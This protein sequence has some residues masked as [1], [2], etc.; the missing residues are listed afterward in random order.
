M[1]SLS[2]RFKLSPTVAAMTL[3]AFANGSPDILSVLAST[4]KINSAL[5]SLG[6]LF[7]A[8]LCSTTLVTSNVILNSPEKKVVLPKS[9]VLKDLIFYLISILIIIFFGLIQTAGYPLVITY[10]SCYILY[11]IVSIILEKKAA[12][13][14]LEQPTED[15]QINN[16]DI[17]TQE[18]GSVDEDQTSQIG[19]NFL[20]KLYQDS[21]PQSTDASNTQIKTLK[22][23]D[24]FKACIITQVCNQLFWNHGCFLENVILAPLKL[25]CMFTNCYL[26]NP[27]MKLPLRFII[28]SNTFVLVLHFLEVDQLNGPLLFIAGY[29]MGILLCF[30]ELLKV[31]KS[32]MKIIYE[33]ISVFGAIGY[34]SI[35]AGL[36]IDCIAFLAFYFSLNEIILATLL[37]S[38]GNTVDDFFSNGALARG[39][40]SVMAMMT[41][42]SGQLFNN[43]MGLG[44]VI[45][46]TANY[47]VNNFDIFGLES[48]HY[49][50]F[51][52]EDPSRLGNQFIIIVLV[53]VV[54]GILLKLTYFHMNNFVVTKKFV[55]L[56]IPFYCI[57]I[58]VSMSFGL[59]Y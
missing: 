45:L 22:D 43:F 44:T 17:D 25:L 4:S 13:N 30:I 50:F 49:D 19:S 18:G 16:A 48:T 32:I 15:L 27:L 9:A 6:S 23:V 39:G 10:F 42:Y 21:G 2:R 12:R 7:G 58:A 5:I 8:F 35:F 51:D 11:V 31:R 59:L 29:T 46:V 3:L 47:G 37:L 34:I 24:K 28:V 38:A 14:K 55:K 26:A 20:D 33:F 41:V 54:I 36:V 1:K 52:D 53:F 40:E 56:M 57:F